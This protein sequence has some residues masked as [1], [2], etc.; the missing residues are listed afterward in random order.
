[1]K[2]LFVLAGLCTL[3]NMAI[4]T[5]SEAHAGAKL[6]ISEPE[7]HPQTIY[8]KTKLNGKTVYLPLLVF[9]TDTVGETKSQLADILG[10]SADSITLSYQGQV[11]NDD[12]T[13]NAYG[14][15]TGAILSVS[16]L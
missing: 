5:P 3:F 11:L 14:I 12:L 1:V 8:A 2:K 4:A 13:L 16:L 15:T 7:P 6:T 10:V 9:F